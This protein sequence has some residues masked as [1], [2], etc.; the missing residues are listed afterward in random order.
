[1]A[2]E[3]YLPL[4][5]GLGV[6]PA[7]HPDRRQPRLILHR[8]DAQLDLGA[9]AKGYIVDR[10]HRLLDSLGGAGSY[11][12]DVRL[13]G[14]GHLVAGNLESGCRLGV[15]MVAHAADAK[16]ERR[17]TVSACSIIRSFASVTSLK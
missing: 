9:I 2:T 8:N 10:L 15:A 16:A 14:A 12:G 6:S 17:S 4:L 11:L 13:D 1:M 7:P 5:P 3:P